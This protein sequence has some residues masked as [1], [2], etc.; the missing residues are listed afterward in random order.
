MMT[1]VFALCLAGGALPASDAD[2]L[3][4]LEELVRKQ[5]DRIAALEQKLADRE[6]RPAVAM[7]E[8]P[9]QPSPAPAAPET[10][11]EAPRLAVSG[12]L[13][14]RQEFNWGAADAPDRSRNTLRARLAARYA[15]TDKVALGAR[16]VTGNPDDPNSTDV[17]ISDF[18]DNFDVSLDQVFASVDLGDFT[19]TAGKFPNPLSRTD[20]VWDGDVNPQ[21]AAIGYQAG[22]SPNLKVNARALYLAIEE[23]AAGKGSSMTG[24]QL[25]LALQGGSDWRLDL[26]GA[27]YDYQLHSLATADAGDFRTNNMA[28]DGHYLSDFDLAE[29]L[30]AVTYSGLG[31]KWPVRASLDFVRNLGAA[32]NDDTA[33]IAEITIGTAGHRGD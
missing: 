28:P 4:A 25:G 24:G 31:K 33:Y 21:G 5:N 15:L 10:V 1:S 26:S 18:V 7:T 3:A 2:R 19:L 22:L 23:N 20:L 14:L 32:G 29:A 17:T 6:T 9:S 30:G 11:R 8:P 12:D 16:L 27:Y 13:R